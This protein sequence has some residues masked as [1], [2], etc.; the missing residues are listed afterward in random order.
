MSVSVVNTR[1]N[2]NVF[3]LDL[4]VAS[5]LLSVTVLGRIVDLLVTDGH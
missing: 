3:N 2:R 1:E 4:D 5:E